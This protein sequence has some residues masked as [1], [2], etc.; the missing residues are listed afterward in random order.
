MA[1]QINVLFIC[2]THHKGKKI[3]LSETFH[4]LYKEHTCVRCD[5]HNYIWNHHNYIRDRHNYIYRTFHPIEIQLLVTEVK[6]YI[7]SQSCPKYMY[8]GAMGGAPWS[9]VGHPAGPPESEKIK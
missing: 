7:V 6:C 8:M 9:E 2:R 3:Y 4:A 5:N 1:N